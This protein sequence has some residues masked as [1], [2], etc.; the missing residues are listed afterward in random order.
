MALEK[1]IEK[2]ALQNAI[3][4]NGK[5]QVSAVLGKVISES[6][7]L[8]KDI[9]RVIVKVKK[10]VD[11]VNKLSVDEQKNKLKKLA[12]ELLEKKKKV[13]KEL[14]ELKNAVKG[15]VITRIPPEPSKYNHIGHA[16]SF[17]INYL[18][19]KKYK[20]KCILRFEDTNPE[21]SKQ[22]YVDAMKKDV[23]DYLDIKPHKTIFISDDLPKLY[24]YAEELI[25]KENAYV[26]F[27]EKQ[28]MRD[29]RARGVACKCRNASVDANLNDW[30]NMLHKKFK[31]GEATLRLKGD[32][33]SNNMVM[34]DPVLFRINYTQHYRQKNKFCVW[35]TYDFANALEDSLYGVTH[36]LRSAE[37]GTM[38]VELQ[39]YIKDLLRLRKQTI[40]Q[41][42][43]FNV[44]GAVTQGRII[45][46]MI[47]KKKV[48]G[49]D[50]PRLVTLR[51]LKRRGIAKETFYELAVEVGTSP[52]PTH[53]DFSVIAAINRKVLDPKCN[54]Y[55]FVKDPKLITIKDA[56]KLKEKVKIAL[57]PDFP[58]RGFRKFDVVDNKFYISNDDFKNFKNNKLYRLM[59][60][61]N[62]KKIKNN[63]VFDSKEVE[64]YRKKGTMIMHWLPAQKNLFKVEV[65]M[66]D[67]KRV[68]GLGEPLMKK[69]KV[70]EII[71]AERFGFTKLDKKQK[72]KLI[73]WYAHK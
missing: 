49:W 8:K 73:F 24:K 61:L 53:I 1:E 38:R 18:Y 22:E 27:C 36:I 4:F 58:R 15:K 68:K 12:P 63:F 66:P 41:Y 60:C 39:N 17:L 67:A 55:F 16:L 47:K 25:K 26:C 33:E 35:P 7:E 14:P 52:A 32:L 2:Y 3:N 10:I 30:K 11:N 23:L 21:T 42:G 65:V 28:R 43:R 72:D 70:G 56:P 34:R 20:G 46:E 51:A 59:E 29:L 31:Q 64:T 45:R 40:I 6:P 71:Q 5:A 57:H 44:E 50:D 48:I 9:K 13:K 54:R 19:A 69:I 37:F 62:F